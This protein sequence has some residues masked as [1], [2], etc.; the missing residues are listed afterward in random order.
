MLVMA[1]SSRRVAPWA[2]SAVMLLATDARAEISQCHV[3]EVDFIPATN[4]STQSARH[5]RSQMVMWLERADGLYIDTFYITAETGR[6]GLGNR[7]GRF[8]FNSGPMW[9][10]GRRITTFPVWAHRKPQRYPEVVFQ[11]MEGFDPCCFR[12]CMN[13]GSTS[14]ETCTMN[15]TFGNSCDG[16]TGIDYMF[17]GENQLS[18]RACSSSNEL[19]YCRPF[20]I[21]WDPDLEAWMEADAMTCATTVFTDKGKLSTLRESLYPPRLDVIKTNVDSPS[22]DLFK[23]LGNFDSVS[24]ATPE[25]GTPQT[26]SWALPFNTPGGNYVMWAEVSQAFDHNEVYNPQSQPPPPGN[27]ERAISWTEYGLPYRGQPSVVYAVPFT[28]ATHVTKATTDQYV[29][30]GAPDGTDGNLRAPDVT[31]TTDTPGSGASRLQ[32]VSDGG[33]LYRIRVVARPE[34]DYA[35]P[36]EIVA[37]EVVSVTPNTATLR[38]V[39]PGDDGHVGNI[40]SYDVRYMAN[41]PLTQANFEEATRATAILPPGKPGDLQTLEL[42]GLLPE[43]EYWVG[44]RA[45]DDCY[46]TGPVSI[47]KVKTADRPVGSVDACFIATAAYGSAMAN[48]VELLRDFRDATLRSTVLGELAIETYYTFGPPVAG[49]IGQ[50]DVLRQTARG[51]VQPIVGWVRGAR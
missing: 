10:Y 7:P 40:T 15:C 11:D 51:M 50:S 28:I 34:F 12:D 44:I 18:H 36:G 29:G 43:T 35:S 39:A 45:L 14:A 17:C 25:A 32:L 24:R 48:D 13:G 26:V 23:Q 1:D 27:G 33:D 21:N 16:L 4:E 20:N 38:F 37:N 49:V 6:F 42:F 22:V 19:H 2:I 8:D 9:P 3:I 5:E 41:R 47:V 30:Y 46:N 31:I